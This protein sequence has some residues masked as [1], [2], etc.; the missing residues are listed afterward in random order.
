ML[1][2][3]EAFLDCHVQY[4]RDAAALEFHFKR[5]PVITFSLAY[6]T[7]NIDIRKKMH[8]NLQ[9]P[10]SLARFAAASL[11]IKAE[12]AR[13]IAAHPGILCCSKY[14]SYGCEGICI[15][16]GIRARRPADG[17]LIYDDDFIDMLG[18]QKLI[19]L[20]RLCLAAVK[21]LSKRP[22]EDL[23]DESAF[24]GARNAGYANKKA[25]RN[26]YINI[27]EIMLPGTHNLEETTI[28]PSP[29]GN[30]DAPG[31]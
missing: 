27:L 30:L 4:F 11:H 28:G 1:E 16:G 7:G 31:S 24:T 8:L 23:I 21:F 9:D 12:S 22:V 3:L 10:I 5:F 26:F 29:A 13:S 6:F 20:S 15:G 2:E 19:M 25:Q 18:A 14:F 17:G